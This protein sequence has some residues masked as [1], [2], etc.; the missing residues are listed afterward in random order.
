MIAIPIDE[1]KATIIS[2][3][4]GNAPYFALLDESAKVSVVEN[5]E[6]GSGPKSALFLKSI[7]VI[8]TVFY[9]MGEG[10]YKAFVKNGISVYSV[11][12]NAFSLDDIFNKIKDNALPKLTE[13][14]YES[15]LDA[16]SVGSC[17]C[18]CNE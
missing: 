5:A 8:S 6:C 14:N 2:E 1:P 17:K 11:E 9:H 15:L 13:N 12:K 10:V 4:Y 18:G 16:G 3:L 7:D